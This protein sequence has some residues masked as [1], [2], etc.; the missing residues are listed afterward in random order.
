MN[1][2]ITVSLAIQEFLPPGVPNRLKSTLELMED[3]VDQA[4]D[5]GADLVAFPEM[6][7]TCGASD[8]WQFEPLDG[9]TLA[10]MARKARQRGI[11]II[12]PLLTLEDGTRYNSSVLIGPDGKTLG[13]YHKYFPTHWELDHGIRPGETTPVFETDW[14]RICLSICFDLNYWEVGAGLCANRAELVIW[15]SMWEGARMLTRWAIEFGFYMGAVYTNQAT[16]VD[17]AGREISSLR[18]ATLDRLGA[19]PL[20]TA[21]LDLDRRLLHHD[22]NLDRL[23]ALFETYGKTAATVEHLSQECLVVFGSRLADKSSEALMAEFGLES[24]RDYEARA[25]RDR[26]LVLEGK[27]Q[28]SMMKISTD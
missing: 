13:H 4:V 26:K 17:L 22:Y 28:P 7:N 19:A 14:G 23:P 10:A 8:E 18:R 21:T 24:K 27:Y 9:P 16:F 12:C 20:L 15:S 1:R 3:L 2:N 5:T 11:A 25:R 6:S